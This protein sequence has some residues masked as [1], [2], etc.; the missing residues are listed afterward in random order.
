MPQLE[1]TLG[2]DF[3]EHDIRHDCYNYE[4]IMEELLG[5]GLKT[6]IDR[7]HAPPRTEWDTYLIEK[8]VFVDA[9]NELH[10]KQKSSKEQVENR[11]NFADELFKKLQN[12]DSSRSSGCTIL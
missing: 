6:H 3:T 7:S 5:Q 10:P 8:Y 4:R 11:V 2:A 12:V 9:R 1:E